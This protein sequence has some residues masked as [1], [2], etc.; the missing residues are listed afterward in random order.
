MAVRANWTTA[1]MMNPRVI[2]ALVVQKAKV[3]NMELVYD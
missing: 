1:G 2:P 3:W